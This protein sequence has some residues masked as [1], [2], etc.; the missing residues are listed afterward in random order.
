MT[1]R[2]PP[3]PTGTILDYLE[4]GPDDL[5]AKPKQGR[6]ADYPLGLLYQGPW[7]EPGDG[8]CEH[9]RRVARAIALVGC[10]VHLRSLRFRIGELATEVERTCAPLVRA[11]IARYSA[12]IQQ[13]V[14]V[15]GALGQIILPSVV[16]RR[17]L[18]DDDVRAM[19]RARV[20]STV[21][22]RWPPLPSDLAALAAV[23]QVWVACRDNARRLVAAGLDEPRV[24]VVPIPYFDDD[25]LVGKHLRPRV[26]GVPRFLHIGK[27]E[28]RKAQDRIVRAFLCAFRPS[29]AELVLKTAALSVPIADYP[30]GPNEAIRAALAEARVQQNGWS[31]ENVSQWLRVIVRRLSDQRIRELHELSDVYVSASRGE[32]FDMPAFDAKLAGNLLVYVPSGGPQD[33][34]SPADECVAAT[35]EVACHPLY[36]WGAGARYLDYDEEDLVRA[37]QRAAGRVR[38]GRRHETPA[39]GGF[40]A[41]AVGALAVEHV[42]DL[43]RPWDGK[44]FEGDSP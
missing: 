4:R 26:V 25:P 12:Y 15:P 23:G 19:L 39:L 30:Q 6:A 43:I 27:W 13:V 37:L 33:F 41:E 35:G 22:E 9:V 1:Q 32:G 10:P 11:S 3:H 5:G 17:V 20:V 40:R 29:E 36:G 42:R 34:A 2:A 21:W 7:E 16:A 24:R 8:F 31:A 18:S 14:P 28:P 38:A 44:V